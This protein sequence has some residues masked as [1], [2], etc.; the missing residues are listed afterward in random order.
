MAKLHFFLKEVQFGLSGY[1]FLGLGK[2]SARYLY[3]EY[4]YEFRRQIYQKNCYS[5]VYVSK[6]S[7][8]LIYSTLGQVLFFPC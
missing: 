8:F 6:K 5:D 7:P 1:E 2:G 3:F 4:Y